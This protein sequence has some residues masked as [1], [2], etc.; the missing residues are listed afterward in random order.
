MTD[1]TTTATVE[2]FLTGADLVSQCVEQSFAP[3]KYHFIFTG[4]R[5]LP[6]AVWVLSFDC[7]YST[8]QW[9]IK[10]VRQVIVGCSSGISPCCCEFEFGCQE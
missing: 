5:A 2:Y 7:L 9:D 6:A 3:I 1:A 4:L 10:N 8:L